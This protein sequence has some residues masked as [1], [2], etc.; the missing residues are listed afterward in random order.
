MSELATAAGVRR[1]ESGQPPPLKV[2]PAAVCVVDDA[3]EAEV[4]GCC[5]FGWLRKP[6]RPQPTVA[7]ARPASPSK[8]TTGP[9][10]RS[11]QCTYV[12]EVACTTYAPHARTLVC[13][14]HT[15]RPQL[16][17]APPAL[18]K[19]RL[20]LTGWRSGPDFGAGHFRSRSRLLVLC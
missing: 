14:A 10:L 7:D 4:G 12:Y 19:V 15:R 6:K 9:S 8:A 2:E 1:Q 11:T 16:L 5:L 13:I 17:P 3:K 18:C 20:Q